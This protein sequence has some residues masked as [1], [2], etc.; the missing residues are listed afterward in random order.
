MEEILPCT[1]HYLFSPSNNLWVKKSRWTMH[2][3]RTGERKGEYRFLVGNLEEKKTLN[4]L[5]LG[6]K[7][8]I[9]MDL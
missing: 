9:K 3:A 8:N 5:R 1:I 2:V 4:R 6:R 7:N